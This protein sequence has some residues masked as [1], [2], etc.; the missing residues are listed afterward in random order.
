LKGNGAVFL[1]LPILIGQLQGNSA[2]PRK[3]GL[4]MR[5]LVLLGCAVSIFCSGRAANADIERF[6][7]FEMTGANENLPNDS[8]GSG[9]AHIIFDHDLVT[10]R[11]MASFE[12]LTGTTT[13]SHIHC[14][15][16]AP[17]NVGVA[18]TTPTFTGFPNGV[19][20]GTYDHTFDMT[21]AS[22]YNP[23][24][25]TANG[26]ISAALEALLNGARAGNPDTLTGNAYLNIH[27]SFR[28]GGEIRGWLIPVPEPSS[29]LLVL[30]GIAGVLVHRQ[31]R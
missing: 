31:A 10:M 30:F 28:S 22:S 2:P 11:V 8:Q 20:A 9:R 18:T 24:F 7:V 15:T 4:L 25:I 13:A 23:A 21:L 17:G 1:Y 16:P 12:G 5:K 3:D 29:C 27:T 14:C 26:S 19:T 6:R